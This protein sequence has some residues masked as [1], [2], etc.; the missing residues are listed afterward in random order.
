MVTQ[1]GAAHPADAVRSAPVPAPSATPQH[2]RPI[3]RTGELLPVIGCGTYPAF[4]VPPHSAATRPLAQVL[5]SLFAG[6]GRL[7]DT[8]P[9]YG[10]AETVVGELLAE[11]PSPVKP[12]LATKVWTRGG[13][14][15]IAQM[16][17]SFDLLQTDCIDLLQVHNLLDHAQHLPTLRLWQQQGRVRYV[18]I[19]HYTAGS[20]PQLESVLQSEA[21]DFLQI[22][23]SIAERGA[24]QR[25]LPLAAERG[26][27]VI[28]NRPFGG[29]NVLSM[30]R[31]RDLPEFAAELGCHNWAQLLLKFVI[32]HPAVTCAIPSTADP[33]HMLD[34]CAAGAGAL[35]DEALRERIAALLPG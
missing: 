4:D 8:S 18:G 30:L 14:A 12:F 35:P 22:N 13:K 6:G 19:T 29:G 32:G 11:S 27:A 33:S 10:L 1:Q 7:I 3:P 2:L 16:Q 23:Y 17:R 15:G 26:V 21:V 24:E 20:Y 25:L 5:E 34:N 28:V 9:M 31:S